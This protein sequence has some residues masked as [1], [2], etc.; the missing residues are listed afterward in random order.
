MARGQHASVQM[1]QWGGDA[2]DLAGRLCH[3][4]GNRCLNGR[5]D[6]RRSYE[7]TSKWRRRRRTTSTLAFIWNQANGVQNL[8]QVLISDGLGSALTGWTLTA[9]TAITPDG[10]TI[11]GNGIDPQGNT[12][13][14]IANLNAHRR[15]SSRSP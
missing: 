13:G 7:S 15:P 3:R 1:D 12:E 9:A 5:S 2:P 4:L 8:Q 11:V 10:N 6:D 14:W